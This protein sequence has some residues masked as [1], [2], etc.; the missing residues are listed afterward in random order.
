MAY[1]YL[2]DTNI[3]IYI[4]KNRPLIVRRR[5]ESCQPGELA[6]SVITCGE[7][8]YGAEKSSRKSEAIKT[9]DQLMYSIV[10]LDIDETVTHHYGIIRADLE[11]RGLVIGSNDLWIAAHAQA[12]GLTLVTNNMREFSRIDCLSV[13]NWASTEAM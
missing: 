1:K 2:L 10:V 7:L 6:M 12:M 5:L 8:R 9:I 11:R 3:C 13:E 4:A